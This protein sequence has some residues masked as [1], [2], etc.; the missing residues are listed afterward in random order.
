L[1]GSPL[2]GISGPTATRTQ[3]SVSRRLPQR[4][5]NLLLTLHIVVAVG[6][7]GTDA[8]LLTL[9]VTGL[10]SGDANVIRAAYVAMDV[11]VSAVLLPLAAGALLTGVLLGLG[12]HWGLTRHYWVLTKLVLTIVVA[13]AAVVSLRPSLDQAAA[14]ALSVPLAELPT[15]GIG[16]VGVGVTVAPAVALLVLISTVILAVYKPWGQRQR[17]RH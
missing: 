13:T 3:P 5:R 17:S 9:G 11:L 4:W 12:T 2:A 16:R 10:V 7:L 6:A 8:G 14:I 1:T 15:V